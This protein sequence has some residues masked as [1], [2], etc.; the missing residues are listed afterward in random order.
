MVMEK[1]FV[2]EEIMVCYVQISFD[3]VTSDFGH[4]CVL[5]H[6]ACLACCRTEKNW[7]E[8]LEH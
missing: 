5:V 3:E 7:L 6:V 4:A 8:S 1:V 2:P